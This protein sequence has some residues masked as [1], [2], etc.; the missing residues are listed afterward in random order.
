MVKI[1]FNFYNVY[2]MYYK[3]F[4]KSVFFYIDCFELFK[5]KNLLLCNPSSFLE[6]RLTN[7]FILKSFILKGINLNIFFV[8]FIYFNRFLKKNF[9]INF[10]VKLK[11]ITNFFNSKNNLKILLKI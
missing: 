7:I 5:L 1:K 11:F 4:K 8:S 2:N 9:Y 6:Y 3:N 10:N